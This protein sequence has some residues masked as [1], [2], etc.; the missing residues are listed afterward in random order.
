MVKEAQREHLC[1]SCIVLDPHKIYS[2][3]LS[4][5]L[6]HADHSGKVIWDMGVIELHDDS[7][8]LQGNE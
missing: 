6:L 3:T 7:K 4:C 1:I 2:M 8:L 5:Q